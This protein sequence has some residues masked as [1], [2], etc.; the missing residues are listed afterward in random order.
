M[1]DTA[2]YVMLLMQANLL[3]GQVGGRWVLE[4][5]TLLG[6][7]AKWHSAKSLMPFHKA[8]KSLDFQVPHSPIWPR[9]GFA[10]IKYKS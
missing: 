6:P 1:I 7:K 2:L 10:R 8:K 3:L 4:I 9:N 5:S